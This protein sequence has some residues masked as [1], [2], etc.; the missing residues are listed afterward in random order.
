MSGRPAATLVRGLGPLEA[1]TLVIGGTIGSGIFLAPSIVAREVGA[2]GLSLLVWVVAGILASCGALCYAELGAAIP[3][4]GGTYA[5]VKRIY[6]S[7]LLAF[8]FGWMFFFVDGGGGLAAVATAFGSYAGFFLGRLIPYDANTVKLVAVL[9]I[10]GLTLLNCAGLRAGGVTQNL[11]TALKLGTLLAIISLPFFTGTGSLGRVAPLLPS[12]AGSGIWLAVGAA[13]IPTLFAYNGWTFSTYVAGEIRDPARNLPRS[14]ILGLGV[15]L[16]VYLAANVAYIAVLPFDEL[17]RSTLVASDAMQRAVGPWGAGFA[18]AA[19]VISTFGGLNAGILAYPRIGFALAQDGLFFKGLERV[20]ER[21]RVPARAILLQGATASLF[22]LSGSYERILSYFAFVDYAFFSLAIAGIFLLRRRE[23]NLA[24]PYRVWGY[25]VT[26]LLF[27]AISLVYLV[28][29]V[30][31][32][33]IESLVGIGLTLSG[34]PF[35]LR[36]RRRGVAG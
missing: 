25:P 32:R 26:P 17:Q 23:P 29:L 12:G 7:P 1:T 6:R 5:F 31:K 28:T 30:G 27:I 9:A 15:V 8:L 21:S 33:P 34:V 16:V 3:E 10:V 4:T 24:R 36:W 20:S 22:A 19:V 14:I 2:P 11:L 35:Y 13:M 18:A